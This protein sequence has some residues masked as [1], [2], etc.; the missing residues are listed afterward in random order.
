MGEVGSYGNKQYQDMISTSFCAWWCLSPISRMQVVI[1]AQLWK[2]RILHC[3]TQSLKKKNNS[4]PNWSLKVHWISLR[5]TLLCYHIKC[6]IH[7][8]TGN[9]LR[10][11]TLNSPTEKHFVFGAVL[12]LPKVGIEPAD[13]DGKFSCLPTGDLS[14]DGGKLCATFKGVLNWNRW[15]R[16]SMH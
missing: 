15:K 14:S 6:G 7:I 5:H 2:K 11:T 3:F 13:E 12:T 16:P 10:Q 4:A 8:H 9:T 1:F